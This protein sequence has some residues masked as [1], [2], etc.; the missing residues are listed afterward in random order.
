MFSL[1]TMIPNKKLNISS[2]AEAFSIG[3]FEQAFDYLDENIIWTIIGESEILGKQAVIS[4]CKQIKEYF[5][6]GYDTL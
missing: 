2:I 5:Q 3:E 6:L 1:T 4:H